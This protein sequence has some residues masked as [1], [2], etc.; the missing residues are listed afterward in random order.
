MKLSKII[1]G[2][3]KKQDI[4][5]RW[6]NYK[7]PFKKGSEWSKI[8]IVT[9]NE[10][11][12]RELLLELVDSFKSG[13]ESTDDSEYNKSISEAWC[14]DAISEIM[15]LKDYFVSKRNYDL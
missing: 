3:R 9:E 5:Q 12:N 7:G 11:S 8:D 4:G 2:E 14:D 15:D 6:S 1:L 10:A 13:L